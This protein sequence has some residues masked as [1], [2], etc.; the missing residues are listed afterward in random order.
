MYFIIAFLLALLDPTAFAFG[1]LL[2]LGG[3]TCVLSFFYVNARFVM[4]VIMI[5]LARAVIHLMSVDF[6]T[7]ALS[8]I[9]AFEPF[10]KITDA[11]LGVGLYFFILIGIFAGGPVHGESIY[12]LIKRQR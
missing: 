11:L 8:I 3:V 10:F 4:A 12:Q 6:G 7:E 5:A 1:L 2:A 9:Q